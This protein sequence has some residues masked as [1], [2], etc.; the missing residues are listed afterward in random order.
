MAKEPLLKKLAKELLGPD[1][2][3]KVLKRIE[4]IG[5]IAIIRKPF[6]IELDILKPLAEELINRIKYIKSVWAASS[7]VRGMHR[8]REYV[9]L[10]GERKSET[11]YRE[12]GCVFKLDIT[13]VYIS[14]VLSYDHIRI[15]RSIRNG[16]NVLNMFAG[17]GGYTIIISRY[18]KPCYVLSIDINTYAIKYLKENIELNKVGNINEVILGEAITVTSSLK[19]FFDRVLIPLP[20]LARASVPKAVEV[21]KPC[22]WIHPHIFVNALNKREAILIAIKD[23]ESILRYCNVRYDF[24]NSHVIRSVGPRRYHVVLDIRIEKKFR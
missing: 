7:P 12:H 20:E 19:P 22:G 3:N 1:I 9:H 23:I 18:S 16:E 6:D 24:T 2:A 8:V 4:I 13:K 5:D 14:P 10:A 17:I 21:L 11:I 15:A